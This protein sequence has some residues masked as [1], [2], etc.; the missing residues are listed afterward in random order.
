MSNKSCVPSQPQLAFDLKQK[1][2]FDLE[3][4]LSFDHDPRERFLWALVACDATFAASFDSQ[5]G[6]LN[7]ARRAKIAVWRHKTAQTAQQR[8]LA[9]AFELEKHAIGICLKARNFSHLFVN[10]VR[11]SMKKQFSKEILKTGMLLGSS[12]FFEEKACLKNLFL[13]GHHDLKFSRPTDTMRSPELSERPSGVA[14]V[15]WWVMIVHQIYT[16]DFC[17]LEEPL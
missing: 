4:E 8:C 5:E 12:F 10:G 17:P 16:S 13:D 3:H 1:L 15:W 11:F 9:K 2:S 14:G 6:I 7:A